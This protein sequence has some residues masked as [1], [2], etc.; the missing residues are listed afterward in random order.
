[1]LIN[2][3]YTHS[4]L[5]SALRGSFSYATHSGGRALAA[6]I[7][8]LSLKNSDHNVI[9]MA[10]ELL[11]QLLSIF[12]ADYVTLLQ[13]WPH[14]RSSGPRSL[15]DHLIE[16]VC[17]ILV[18]D[19]AATSRTSVRAAAAACCAVFAAHFYQHLLAFVHKD[20]ERPSPTG[21]PHSAALERILSLRFDEDPL[22]QANA[23]LII[24]V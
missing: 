21:D 5:S 17:S 13:T 14:E 23:R 8:M 12:G 3:R 19:R 18:G 20:H 1:M 10:L 24:G 22:L 4:R 6:G 9:S 2:H 15:I 11:Q 16:A 7:R